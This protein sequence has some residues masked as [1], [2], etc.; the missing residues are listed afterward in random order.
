MVSTQF[1]VAGALKLF[2]PTDADADLDLIVRQMSD[3]FADDRADLDWFSRELGQV[4]GIDVF[5]SEFDTTRGWQTYENERFRVL[6]LRFENLASDGPNA[7][8]TFLALDEV[9]ELPNQNAGESKA[10]APLYRRFKAEASIPA[11]VLDQAYGSA[12]AQHFYTESER[13]GFR[14]SWQP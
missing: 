6:V 14:A 1:Q 5:A 3:L 2:D 11:W 10:Y 4:T 9:P 7:L 8:R 12:L 13:R